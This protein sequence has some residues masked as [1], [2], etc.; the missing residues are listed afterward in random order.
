MNFLKLQ[1][2]EVAFVKY[3]NAEEINHLIKSKKMLE[4][5][6]IMFN[7]LIEKNIRN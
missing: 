3:M 2:E 5:H 7:E 6:G 4:S 1:K